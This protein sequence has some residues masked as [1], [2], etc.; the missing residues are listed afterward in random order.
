MMI[1]RSHIKN[2]RRI[3]EGALDYEPLTALVSPNGSGTSAFLRAL[4]PGSVI[5]SVSG[6]AERREI[7]ANS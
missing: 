6:R 3:L 1:K 7:Y 5:H 4:E 2:F